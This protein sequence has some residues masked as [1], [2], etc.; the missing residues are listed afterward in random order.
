[1]AGRRRGGGAGIHSIRAH[2][3]AC[4]LLLWTA[5]AAALT[6]YAVEA[7]DA[8]GS[9]T[10]AAAVALGVPDHRFVNDA[11]LGY[12]GTNGDVFAPGE[13]TV[14]RFPAPLRNIPGQIDLL[15][16]AFVGGDGASDSALV[17]VAVSSDGITFSSVGTFQTA[18]GR[19][20]LVFPPQETP[21]ASVKHFPIEFG[22]ADRV[23]HVRLTNT[24]GTSEGLRLDAV[25]GLHPLTGA[26]HAFELRVERFRLAD[27][28]RFRLRLKN[29]ADPGGAGIHALRIVPGPDPSRLEDSQV[30]LPALHGSGGSLL[31]VEN[32]IADTTPTSPQPVIPFSRH[33]WSEDGVV[34]APPGIGLD[35]GRQLANVRT[36]N[37]SFDTDNSASFLEGFE[38]HVVFTDGTEQALSFD[39]DILA[40]GSVGALYQKYQYFSATP[41]IS[42]PQRTD[43]Y[44]FSD[45]PP[46]CANG[47]DDDGDGLVDWPDD[48]ACRSAASTRE[49]AQCQDGIDD[50]GD[51]R[52]DF[53]GGA[54]R[55]GGMAWTEPDPQCVDKPF[56]NRETPGACGLGGELALAFGALSGW[57]RRRSAWTR[58]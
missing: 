36:G 19:D 41:Q 28:G 6:S 48:P 24:A 53:D 55:N 17:D 8:A 3:V 37:P 58:H 33:A 16:S 52:I 32:C 12:G 15:V 54:S 46:A 35:P 25:E 26:S 51:G 47:A 2:G 30:S 40:G 5:P 42:E 23:T 21:F 4:V 11:G 57:C 7:R 49:H 10:G 34:E 45:A 29:L 14:L 18:T 27:T 13:S 1:M 39:G 9:S 20:P 38:F 44:E 22:A 50:D 56:R 31:C 43:T